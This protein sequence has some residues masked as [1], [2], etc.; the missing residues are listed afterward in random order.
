VKIEEGQGPTIKRTEEKISK[1][2]RRHHLGCRDKQ[3]E[4]LR[5]GWLEGREKKDRYR[6]GEKSFE[7]RFV[8]RHRKVGPYPRS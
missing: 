5:M 1:K 4:N 7:N 8:R 6:R 3:K 2:M